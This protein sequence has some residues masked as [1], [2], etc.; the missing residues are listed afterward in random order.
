MWRD[1]STMKRTRRTVRH[2]GRA[3]GVAVG[4]T[5]LSLVLSGCLGSSFTFYSH[6]A[7][8]SVDM[9]FKLPNAWK[10]FS[11]KQLIEA[12]NGALSQTQIN[13]VEAG[14]WES[15]FSGSQQPSDKHLIDET[16]AYPN[17]L[18]FARQLTENTHDSLNY[19]ALRAYIL[20][21]DPLSTDPT[22]SST[23]TFDVL[24]Y[25]EFTRPGGIRGSFMVTDITTTGSKYDTFGQVIAVDPSNNWVF[26]IGIACSASCW[27]TNSGLINQV[28]KTWNVKEQ[29]R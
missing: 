11:A 20:G 18:V 2:R 7:S 15:S 26:G 19:S 25:S 13:Q 4:L 6:R 24:N 23:T 10:V 16:A 17:G 28:L 22:S 21:Q 3:M 9:Y 14:Q 12:A 5:C 27:G 8:D 1:G 29:T